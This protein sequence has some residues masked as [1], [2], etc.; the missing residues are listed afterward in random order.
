MVLAWRE[1]ESG[2]RG[3]VSALR[4]MVSTLRESESPLRETGLS[5]TF[6][7]AKLKH[8]FSIGQTRRGPWERWQTIAVA[9]D[10]IAKP[11]SAEHT[12]AN[13][14]AWL[15]PNQ[16]PATGQTLSSPE[17]HFEVRPLRQRAHA[18]SR[19]KKDSNG[20]PYLYYTCTHV[21]KDGSAAECPV[22]SIPARAFE[23]LIVNYIGE[24][25]KHPEIIEAA[26][27]SSNAEKIKSIRPLKNWLRWRWQ[28]PNLLGSHI[29]RRHP[30]FPMG[31]GA[32]C[33]SANPVS[34]R[35]SACRAN[36]RKTCSSICLSPSV[37]TGNSLAAG[38]LGGPPSNQSPHRRA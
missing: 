36:Q 27:K 26:V 25:G 32:F 3:T 11:E 31:G 21:T 19:G 24:I 6:T 34:A 23:D 20:E 1:N 28:K 18:V 5:P 14:I 8:W 22:R 10:Q 15:P 37:S 13:A 7:D 9:A 16:D 38:N 12:S 29:D 17:R 35:C 33:P 4:E 30:V 2:L